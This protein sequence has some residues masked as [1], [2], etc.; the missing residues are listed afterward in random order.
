MNMKK[1][2]FSSIVCLALLFT[3]AISVFAISAIVKEKSPYQQAAESG[4][5]LSEVDEEGNFKY[6]KFDSVEK[7]VLK[8]EETVNDNISDIVLKETFT[9]PKID[10]YNKMLNSID[11]FNTVDLTLETSMYGGENTTIH[12]QTNIDE[13]IAYETVIQN[14]NVISET[15]CSPNS[16]YLTFV[17]NEKKTYNPEYLA[18]FKRLDAPYIPL[19]KR[20]ETAEDGFPCYYYRQ[21]V[22]NCP[23]A[24][25][26]LFPQ[27]ITFSYLKDF[28][29]WKIT[30]SGIKYLGR[31]CT[32]IEG[33]TAS[34]IAD[35]HSSDS[36]VMLVDSETGVLMKFEGVQN[37]KITNYITVTACE[38][39][40]TRTAI[41]Q[42]DVENYSGYK[43]YKPSFR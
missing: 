30:N 14:G 5:P 2:M 8:N 41:K 11:N 27:E 36:F 32:R 25:Y 6:T 23:L 40:K 9:D 31:I 42:F 20:I 35:K 3:T 24:S 29:K 33:T 1:I 12:Y 15:Y 34:Y 7:E 39:G 17:D 16:K 22:T 19:A 13:N 21:N 26:S 37:G 28:D 4:I 38:F 10:I 18:P 43:E